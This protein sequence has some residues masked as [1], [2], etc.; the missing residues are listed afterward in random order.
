MSNKTKQVKITPAKG[1]PMLSWIGKRPLRA[2]PAMPAQHVETFDPAE[3][4]I[5]REK[6]NTW[7]DWPAGYHQGGLLFHG[8]N[9]EVLAHLLA[10]GFRGKIKLVYIDPPFASGADYVRKVQLRGLKGAATIDAEQYSLGE[11]IQYT[12]IWANDNY[13]QFIYERLILLK[14]L[15]SDDGTIWLH[16]DYHKNHLLRCLLDEVYGPQNLQNEVVWQRTDPHND[17]FSRLGWVHDTLLWYRK[18]EKA[19]Y[20]W[21]EVAEPLSPAALKEY[22]LVKLNDGTVVPYT[23]DEFDGKGRRFKLDDCTWKGNDPTRKFEWR[24][25]RPSDKRIWPYGFDGMEKAL[26]RGEFY[27]R[28]PQKGAARCRVSYLDQREGQVLQTIWT[29]CG[30]MKGG[31]DYP[32]EKPPALLSRII[33]ASSNPGD[34]VLDCFV[35]SGTTAATAQTL[36]RRWIGCDINKG[37]IQTTSKRLQSIIN[38]QSKAG[39]KHVQKI[40]DGLGNEKEKEPEPAQL[41]FTVWR[42]NDYD[43]QIQHNEAV[44][45]ACEYI[46]V[47]RKRSDTYFD[48]TLGKKLVKIVPFNHPLS[49]LDLEELDRELKS[50][51]EE[52]RDIVLVCLGMELAAQSWIEEWNK[53]RGKGVPNKVEI[54]ELRT[55]PKYAGFIKHDPATAKVTIK[56]AGKQIKVEIEDFIS[57]S[58]IKR[59][60]MEQSMFKTKITDWRSQ[61][62]CVLIDTAYDGNVFNVALSDVPEKREDLVTGKYEFQAPFGKTAVAVKIIDMLGEEVLVVNEPK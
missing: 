4:I 18:G 37:A 54:I 9:K 22:S 39:S 3:S 41:A 14:E 51:P 10:N 24:G 35:G 12:D 29:E 43:L 1:R 42:V 15:L 46:G 50:R 62:D 34:I 38:K 53:L 33:L 49:P 44:N 21:R 60:D 7:G 55:N 59:L 57:P 13:L 8:D 45:L 28:N 36:G 48:G 56:R 17:A 32:T 40:L 25:A 61:V 26:E 11:Q 31:V 16:C 19:N 6:S 23:E 5:K 20:N 58:I 2:I 47:E 52:D 30:R 27:L